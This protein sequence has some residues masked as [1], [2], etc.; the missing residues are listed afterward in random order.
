VLLTCVT[1]DRA[2][3]DALLQAAAA[4]FKLPAEAMA[5]RCAIGPVDGC[6]ARIQ[7]FVDAGCTK[8]VLFPL[9]P[10]DELVAQIEVY[11][12]RLIPRFEQRAAAAG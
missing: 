10:P 7:A 6:A 8:F 2:R 1:D 5:E 9:T 12:Q 4:S 11:G 3:A